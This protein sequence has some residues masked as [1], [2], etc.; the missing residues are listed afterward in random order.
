MVWVWFLSAAV[1]LPCHNP[2]IKW[3]HL[4]KT[5]R[6]EPS[7][8]IYC[9]FKALNQARKVLYN[10]VSRYSSHAQLQLTSPNTLFPFSP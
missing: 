1:H 5:P 7:L 3:P 6:L 2:P 9:Q 4:S 8:A 10:L